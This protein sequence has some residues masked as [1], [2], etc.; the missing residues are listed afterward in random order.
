MLSATTPDRVDR[1]ENIVGKAVLEA[2]GS[3]M[4]NKYAEGYQT[5]YYGGCEFVDVAED[6]A[7]DGIKQL[8]GC[9]FANVQPHSGS[10]TEFRCLS[11]LVDAGRYLC[12]DV[13]RQWRAPD[14]WRE[15]EPIGEVVQRGSIR[16]AS[17]GQRIDYDAAAALAERCRKLL[18][19]ADRRIREIDFVKFREIADY[20]G[21]YFMVDMAH[22]AGLVAGGV[23]PSPVPIADVVTFTTHKTL[24][25]PRGGASMTNDEAIAKKVNSAIFPGIQG[26]PA[27]ACHRGESGGLWGSLA[28]EFKSYALAVADNAEIMA[29]TLNTA[30]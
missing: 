13:A 21:A 27:Y 3:I 5:R 30:A 28:P 9:A 23:H 25:G 14:A 6:L 29:T 20:V 11:G 16:C 26:E 8:L 19:P 17:A 22:F 1:V 15:T 2:S 7:I 10:H 12:G 24:R 18:S 4:T